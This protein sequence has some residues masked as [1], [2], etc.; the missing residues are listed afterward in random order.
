MG[1]RSNALSEIVRFWLQ[2]CYGLLLRESIPVKLERNNSD[3][4]FVVMSPN[5]SVTLLD[6]ITFK[7]AIVE[8]KDER[9]YDPLGT[10][11][12]KR[13][14]RD[15][16]LLAE[17]RM[18]SAEIPCIFSMLKEQHHKKAEKIFGTEA[19]FSKIFIF[20][21][22]NRAGLADMI[23]DLHDRKIHFVTSFEMLS[24]IQKFFKESRDGAGIRNSL[25]GDILDMLVTYHKW[26]M[27]N[28]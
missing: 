28:Q 1:A 16:N 22:L 21:N 27:L 20:H 4:D 5:E 19:D 14:R 17:N 6:R 23:T 7:N 3:I 9:D 18:I 12:A 15:Y 25:V 11:I 2:E 8:V 13:L 26:G 24:D 10:D